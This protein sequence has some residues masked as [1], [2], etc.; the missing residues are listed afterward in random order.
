MKDKCIRIPEDTN[1]LLEF[2][3]IL[4]RKVEENNPNKEIPVSIEQI[5]RLRSIE[6]IYT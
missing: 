4:L 6:Q 2:C 5:K 3:R 1:F